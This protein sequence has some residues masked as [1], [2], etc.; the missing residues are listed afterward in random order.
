MK[1]KHFAT[2]GKKITSSFTQSSCRSYHNFDNFD[3][4]R[5]KSRV[6]AIAEVAVT[7]NAI[8]A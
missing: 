3:D 1:S 7:L 6:T 5:Y 2:Y 8:E 4:F